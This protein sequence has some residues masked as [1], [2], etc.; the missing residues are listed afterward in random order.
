MYGNHRG[1]C[2]AK[3][4]RAEETEEAVWR[5]VELYWLDP[6]ALFAELLS[7]DAGLANDASAAEK[8]EARLAADLAALDEQAQS[9]WDLQ[10]A[11]GL[12]LEW[13]SGRLGELR[14]QRGAL[15]R[16]QA[17]LQEQ[18]AVLLANRTLLD[19]LPEAVA[20]F[21]AQRK[22][23]WR[24]ETKREFLTLTVAS[25]EL[26]TLGTGRAKYAEITLRVRWG[27]PL[28]PDLLLDFCHSMPQSLSL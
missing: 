28:A 13:V 10:R 3:K 11:Q 8:E 18:R 9:V 12:P 24:K 16:Q 26:K 20:K 14:D 17:A 15:L 4:L 2:D 21:N 7:R 23:G 19:R 5:L 1:T 6:E 27:T 22:A 25:G